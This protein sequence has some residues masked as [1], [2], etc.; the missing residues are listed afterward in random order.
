MKRIYL[1]PLPLRIWHWLFALMVIILIITGIQ[2]YLPGIA[3]TSPRDPVLRIHKL[4]ARAMGELWVLWLVYSLV[5]RNITRH[6][7]FR[8]KDCGG[9]FRQAKFYLVSMFRGGEN[10]FRPSP[11]EKYNPLLKLAYGSLM[12]VFVPVAVVTGVL[13]NNMGFLRFVRR[14]VLL[15]DVAGLIN[16]VHLA[17]LYVF[18]LFLVAHVYLVTLGRTVFSSTKAMITGYQEEPDERLEESTPVQDAMACGDLQK[19]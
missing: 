17:G 6:Y 7:L 14:Y 11:D 15:W 19:G 3:S 13:F 10:P 1:H 18:L 12:F 5:T 8:R 2:L 4:A 9:L 16:A